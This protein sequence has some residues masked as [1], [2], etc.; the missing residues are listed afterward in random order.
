M[1]AFVVLF[2][3]FGPLVGLILF[4]IWRDWKREDILMVR[5]TQLEDY[6]KDTLVK[7]VESTTSVIAQNTTI[8]SGILKK[9]AE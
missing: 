7:L 8:I 9:F 5:I 6:Q 2:K 3:D 4:F 1:E